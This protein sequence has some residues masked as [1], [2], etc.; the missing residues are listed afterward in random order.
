MAAA[1]PSPVH[2][3]NPFLQS[4]SLLI[5]ALPARVLEENPALSFS[6]TKNGRNRGVLRPLVDFFDVNSAE[7]AITAGRK[8]FGVS[9]TPRLIKILP[10]ECT[11]QT[12]YD[13]LRP[14]G[15]IYSVRIHPIAGGLVQFWDETHAQDAATQLAPKMILNAYDPCSL[16]CSNLSLALDACAFRTHFVEYGKITNAVILT[17][18]QTGK[19]R[20][21]GIITFSQA[22]EA[23]TALQAMHGVE[24]GWKFMSVSY[25]LLNMRG[26]PAPD[27]PASEKTPTSEAPPE[28]PAQSEPPPAASTPAFLAMDSAWCIL[29]FFLLSLVNAQTDKDPSAKP[30]APGPQIKTETAERSMPALQVLYDTEKECRIATQAENES[31]RA[32]LVSVKQQG[33]AENELLREELESVK[34]RGDAENKLLREELESVKQQGDAENKLLREELESVKQQGDAENKLLREELESVKQHDAENKLLLEELESVKQHDAEN[35]LLLEELESVIQQGDAENKLLREELE[36][37]KQNNAENELLLAE[38]ERKI[39]EHETR[40]RDGRVEAEDGAARG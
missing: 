32:E 11:E 28:T 23:S 13:L 39:G 27:K 22:S 14:Y 17:D 29:A 12:L 20:G 31:L 35:E 21:R 2:P 19:S 24:I 15:P 10:A 4:P 16:Y 34:Q 30:H 1:K 37:A 9:N 40:A 5:D 38:A 33:D 8:L 36:S 18:P 26:G 6:R 25:H 7:K 3:P